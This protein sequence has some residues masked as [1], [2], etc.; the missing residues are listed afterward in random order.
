MHRTI[1]SDIKVSVCVISYNHEK[2]IAQCLDSILMQECSF[3]FEVVIRDDCSQDQ[4]LKII[5]SYQER[6][7][8]VIR[9]IDAEK[10]IGA[11]SNLLTVFENSHGK[12]IAICEGDDYWIENTKLQK[13]LDL[14]EAREDL[15]FVS[16]ACRLHDQTGLAS[17][18]HLKGIGTT[19]VTCNDVLSISGQF[20]PTA[21]YMF[22]RNVVSGLPWWF[23]EAPVG[24]FFIEMYGIAA[25]KGVHIN[26][27]LS[28]YRV[29]SENSW[30]TRNNENHFHK[31]VSFS[32]KMNWCLD[33]MKE[34]SMFKHCDFSRKIAA[35]KFNTAI[36]SLLAKDFAGFTDAI[37]Q[38]WIVFPNLSLTQK[39]LYEIRLFPRFAR[40]LYRRK[41]GRLLA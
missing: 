24:D 3:A 4:T 11:N 33:R 18:D 20:A 28:A 34:D 2:Y 7:P 9:L 30:S 26:I 16:H 29:F 12:Y 36:G 38:C 13:Q 39:V 21:S 22:K 17:I 37:N 15:T 19:E 32:R 41:R 10:N 40:F 25:G 27:A 35:V 1:S 5:K 31:L 6:Y 23:K 14:M 8:E